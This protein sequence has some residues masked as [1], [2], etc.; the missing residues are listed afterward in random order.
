MAL[1]YDEEG[2]GLSVGVGG[3][4]VSVGIVV[5]GVG[6][7]VEG[8]RRVCGWRMRWRKINY[9]QLNC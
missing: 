5:D 7:K 8:R 3:V 2:V 1:A 4:C 9:A 6:V